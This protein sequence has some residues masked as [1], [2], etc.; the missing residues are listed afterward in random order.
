MTRTLPALSVMVEGEEVVTRTATIGVVLR[1][2]GDRACVSSV[3][4]AVMRR[5]GAFCVHA[6]VEQLLHGCRSTRHL[7]AATG[8]LQL[9]HSFI[10]HKVTAQVALQDVA[11]GGG[12]V[13]LGVVVER[14]MAT[15][16][17]VVG[18]SPVWLRAGQH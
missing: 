5:P 15:T 17:A 10:F 18:S 16:G 9:L 6:T 13:A 1:G 4:R 11:Y 3:G 14:V 12:V 7:S 8:S 2:A